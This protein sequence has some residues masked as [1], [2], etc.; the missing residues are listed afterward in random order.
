MK[1][2]ILGGGTAGFM[3]AAHLSRY[4]PEIELLHVFDPNIKTIGVGEGT[5][6]GFRIWLD[7]LCKVPFETLRTECDATKKAGVQFEN[8][9]PAKGVFQHNFVPPDSYGLHLSA[10][11]LIP[12]LQ[13]YVQAEQILDHVHALINVDEGV[14]IKFKGDRV[15]L[16]DAVI[17]ARG[18]PK[19]LG[20]QYLQLPWVPTNSALITRNTKVP[21]LQHTR[22]VARP[23]GWIFVIPLSQSTS[24][25]YIY[26]REKCA[27][28]EV[29]RDFLDFLKG[30]KI[31]GV[32]E[33]KHIQFPNFI[34]KRPFDGKIFKI[35]NAASFI[36]PLEAS[37]LA[38]VKGQLEI[39]SFW[40]RRFP[41]LRDQTLAEQLLEIVNKQCF[42]LV[43]ETSVFI[44][45]HYAYGSIYDTPFW[46]NAATGFQSS[47]L[48]LI[49][50]EHSNRLDQHLIHAEK[51]PLE[52][53]SALATIADLRA[54]MDQ[55]TDFPKPFGGITPLGFAQLAHG[56]ET[57]NSGADS[58]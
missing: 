24:Y 18:F 52:K 32:F 54:L 58:Q 6:P 55:H 2:C 38:I 41:L 28:T 36:E 4:F 50:V 42:E 37:S 44:G 56:L 12:F 17:D 20:D 14:E 29:Q 7:E 45:W 10:S 51:V 34:C 27:S 43:L 8:W 47:L 57:G 21:T 30:E 11:R 25:G 39:L 49:P 26:D 35:G 3:A 23:F 31:D 1:V 53:I 15:L 16:V 5:T 48:E 13:H 46:Q 40:L 22:A 33:P 19:A 9:G